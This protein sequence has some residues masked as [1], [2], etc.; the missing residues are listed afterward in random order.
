MMGQ[1]ILLYCDASFDPKS[2]MGICGYYL[3]NTPSILAQ[4]IS[5]SSI[6]MK[7]F[8]ETTCSKLE[9][10][11]INLALQ[12]LKGE[13]AKKITVYTDSQTAAGLLNRRSKLEKKNFKSQKTGLKLS[14][15][16]AYQEFFKLYDKLKPEIIW[17]KG[18]M[19]KNNQT[20][21]NEIFSVVDRAVRK[22]LR[23]EITF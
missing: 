18:H 14:Q 2:K 17:V 1:N 16:D 23:Q 10:E 11:G 8:S 21:I 15:A 3:Q 7:Q 5:F 12:E 4:D 19:A 6:V 9:L 13:P 20:N 22:Q